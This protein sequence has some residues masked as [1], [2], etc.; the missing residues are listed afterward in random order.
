MKRMNR[1]THFL[2]AVLLISFSAYR[3]A[4]QQKQLSLSDEEIAELGEKIFQN[5]AGGKVKYLTWWNE[6]EE[7]A[8]LGIGHFLWYPKNF[9]GPFDESFPKLL[10][11]LKSK[12]VVLPEWMNRSEPIDC[13]WETRDAFLSDSLS[14]KMVELRNFLVGTKGLQA[15]FI[16]Q[17][18]ENALPKMLDAAPDDQREHIL[19]QFY[20]V[21]NSPGGMYP[22]VDYV[23]FKGEG[24]KET[25]RYNGLGWGLLQVL[26]HMQGTERGQAALKDFAESAKFMLDR[27]V[28]NSPPHRNE[29]RWIPGWFRRIDT[30]VGK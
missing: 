1:F 12:N 11:F 21:A 2:L 30:Y 28:K 26:G 22:L 8:S 29:G 15:L 6:G 14:S 10:D 18:L 19:Q 16:A 13:P 27:R 20:R 17:R 7:F 24:V 23:N 9:N 3:C 25:E 5:E 4:G